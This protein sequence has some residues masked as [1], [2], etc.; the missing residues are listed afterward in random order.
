MGRVLILLL[1]LQLLF[2][3][4]VEAQDLDQMLSKIAA[5]S[6]PDL[7]YGTFK[8]TMILNGQSVEVPGKAD[9]HFIV[10]HRFGQVNQGLYGFFGL[11][12]GTTRLGLEYG[13]F[14]LASLSLGR[15][16]Y[17][18][19]V[20]AG[21]KVKLLRQQKGIRNIPVT[22][23]LY[24]SAFI[25]TLE[26]EVPER[27][28]L[29]SSR[30]SYAAQLLIARKF[31]RRLSLQLSPSFIHINLVPER[32]DQNNIYSV[33]AGGR[34]KITPKFS[35]N[36]EYFYLVPGETAED[37]T[38]SLSVGFDI[39]AGGHVFQIIATNTQ[40]MFAREFIAG[41]E[42]KWSEGN[43]FLGFNIYRVFPINRKIKNGN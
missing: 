10:S 12:Q 40:A 33:G 5:D 19:T 14:D 41:T 20:D 13:L 36:G 4:C 7:A 2:V 22:V 1:S 38:N 8:G 11:D 32:E 29:F 31:S 39:E 37:F 28:N 18:K 3:Q 30:L 23:T 27:E 35:L 34:Y 25:K 16:T 15:S 21:L 24:G 6:T 17:E 43:I 42:G 26:W 9:L